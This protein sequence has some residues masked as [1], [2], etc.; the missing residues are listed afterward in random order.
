MDRNDFPLSALSEPSFEDGAATLT[1]F[2]AEALAGSRRHM[3]TEPKARIICGGGARDPVMVKQIGSR[4]YAPVSDADAL[5]WSG[6]FMEA[7]A[8][9]F[10]S[11]VR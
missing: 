10:L 4:L 3:P 6:T 1:A 2:T 8:F 7:E 5:G 9:A 11:T